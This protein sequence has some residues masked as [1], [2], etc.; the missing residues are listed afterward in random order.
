MTLNRLYKNYK[1]YLVQKKQLNIGDT[2][3]DEWYEKEWYKEKKRYE[4]KV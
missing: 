4:K 3:N 1:V 2:A